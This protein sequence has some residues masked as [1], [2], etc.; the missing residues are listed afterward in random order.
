MDRALLL[1]TTSRR[2]HGEA[3]EEELDE[4]ELLAKLSSEELQELERELAALDDHVPIGLRQR[5]QTTKAPSG[6][7]DRDAL[8]RFWEEEHQESTVR[9]GPATSKNI[10]EHQRTSQF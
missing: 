9:P 8:L 6:A 3:L 5:D 1:T 4:D 10:K 7:F 2:H